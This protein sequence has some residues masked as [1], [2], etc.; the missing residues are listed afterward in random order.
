MDLTL[1]FRK[2]P[3]SLQFLIYGY[4]D[5]A[6]EPEENDL[7]MQSTSAFVAFIR[8]I[9]AF[10][11]FCSLEKTLLHSTA[12]SEYTVISRI[13][14]FSSGIKQMFDEIGHAFYSLY[15]YSDNQA[16][17]SIAKTSFCTSAMRHMKIKHH[18]IKKELKDKKL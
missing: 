10:T 15:I 14:E 9:G 16:A 11:A 17:I 8:G 5:F 2:R 12:E 1:S 7:A 3:P 6:G 18:Y 13:G 4:A